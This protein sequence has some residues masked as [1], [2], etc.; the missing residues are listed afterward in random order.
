V[1]R[2]VE[3]LFGRI[4][5]ESTAGVGT[6]VTLTVPT[7]VAL[8][9][10]LMLEEAGV[11]WGLPEAV[12][13]EVIPILGAAVVDGEKGPGLE[14]HGRTIPIVS[15]GELVGSSSHNA[16]HILITS[17]RLGEMAVTAEAVEGVREVAVKELGPVLSGPSH[18]SGAALLGGGDVVLVLETATIFDRSFGDPRPASG[19]GSRVLVVDDSV[20]A[21]AVVSGALASSG[22]STSVASSVAEALDVLQTEGADAVVVDF[23]MPHEDGIALI[24]QVRA[25]FGDLPIVMLSGVATHEDQ[26][27]A[28]RAGVDAFFE[29]TDFREGALAQALREMLESRGAAG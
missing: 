5:L 23:S 28:R 24:D 2:A 27:R 17:H 21:R 14:W 25:R 20:G 18:I 15:F 10:V 13:D 26:E 6:T 11:K 19:Q 9:R 16:T 22:F 7:S 29:K 1:A 8:Q 12:V 3:T 4:K